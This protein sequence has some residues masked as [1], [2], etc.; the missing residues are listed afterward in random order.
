AASLR[1]LYLLAIIA[2]SLFF[3]VIFGSIAAGKW[4][5]VLQY[6]NRE[7][8]GID[9]PQFGRDIGF[10]V[11]TLPFLRF[12]YGWLM[13][14]AVLTTL[15]VSTLYLFRYFIGGYDA[16]AM[17]QTRIHLALLLIAVIALFVWRYWLDRFEMSFSTA[18][19]VFGATYTDIHARL[20]F[21]Y[22]GMAM[23][24]LT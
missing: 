13:G 14:V 17:R 4:E 10:H 16:G 20:P 22:I 1:R 5:I 9:D 3:A 12:A 8:F 11:F 23:G 18:G 7:P 24:V 19:V 15:A 21:L 2:G 6:L